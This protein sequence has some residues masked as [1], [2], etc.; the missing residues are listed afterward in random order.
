MTSPLSLGSNIARQFSQISYFTTNS[1]I[2]SL[3]GYHALT[4]PLH[5]NISALILSLTL[6][7]LVGHF[8]YNYIK[9]SILENASLLIGIPFTSIINMTKHAYPL[10]NPPTF[11]LPL[12]FPRITYSTFMFPS[13]TILTARDYSFMKFHSI[14]RYARI[15]ILA[16][17]ASSP[18]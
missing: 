6:Y 2:T 3:S 7:Q 8:T 18:F 11:A 1:F 4:S 17:L 10:T 12:T 5:S 13:H 14:S 16:Y 15:I 9:Q